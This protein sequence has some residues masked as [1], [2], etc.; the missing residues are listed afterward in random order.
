MAAI[1]N[2]NN[3]F[4]IITKPAEPEISFIHARMPLIISAAQAEN[5]LNGKAQVHE[6]ISQKSELI[7]EKAG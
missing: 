1:Q 6:L 7:F 2:K 4:A 3:E 5:W